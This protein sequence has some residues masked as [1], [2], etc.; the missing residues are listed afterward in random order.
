M[1]SYT[2]NFNCH[3]HHLNNHPHL[4]HYSPTPPPRKVPCHW[5]MAK[6]S[7]CQIVWWAW[8]SSIL[9][10]LQNMRSRGINWSD[11]H[12]RL[13]DG[14]RKCGT[15]TQWDLSSSLPNNN[16]IISQLSEIIDVANSINTIFRLTVLGKPKNHAWNF[17]ILKF[18]LSALENRPHFSSI[19]HN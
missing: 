8:G 17:L 11:V 14:W 16:C 6:V 2:F 10:P 7:V 5:N 19:S 15:Y 9:L 12:R 3:S 1:D 18:C 13:M 4:K